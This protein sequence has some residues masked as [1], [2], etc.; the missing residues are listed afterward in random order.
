[1]LIENGTDILTVGDQGLDRIVE[2]NK[3]CLYQSI[4]RT[5][6]EK[7]RRWM[8]FAGKTFVSFIDWNR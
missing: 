5:Y 2:L 1:M 8:I 6:E 7:G 3:R 4:A